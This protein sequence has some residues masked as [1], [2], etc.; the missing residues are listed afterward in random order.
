MPNKETCELCDGK[1]YREALVSQHDNK[2][3]TV[4]CEM[5]NGKGVIYTMTENEERDYWEDYW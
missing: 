3:E 5:C 1:G 2:K 4:K